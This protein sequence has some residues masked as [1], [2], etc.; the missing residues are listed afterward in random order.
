MKT[1]KF[2]LVAFAAL[3]MQATVSFADDSSLEAHSRGFEGAS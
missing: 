3:V 1:N 2:F